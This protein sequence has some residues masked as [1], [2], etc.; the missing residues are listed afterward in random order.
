MSNKFAIISIFLLLFL[1][2]IDAAVTLFV[3]DAGLGVE[4]N[5][6]MNYFLNLGYLPF[7][8]VK[9]SAILVSCYIFW[10]F[11]GE[12][13]AFI[14]LTLSLLVY[15]SLVTYFGVMLL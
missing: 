12:K 2:I 7:L 1:N 13:L 3:I 6:L 15:F 14:G 5:P 11:K 10:K 8:V 4:V 9:I